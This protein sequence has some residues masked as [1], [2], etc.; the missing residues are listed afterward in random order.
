MG[1]KNGFRTVRGSFYS[2]EKKQGDIPEVMKNTVSLADERLANPKKFDE[3]IQ[4]G[5]FERRFQ[6]REFSLDPKAEEPAHFTIRPAAEVEREM[7][8][9]TVGASAL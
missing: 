7:T 9:Q 8:R 5:V 4:S 1:S 3:Q 2:T 6:L